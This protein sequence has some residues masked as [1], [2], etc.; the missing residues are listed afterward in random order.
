MSVLFVSQQTNDFETHLTVGC[1]TSK[2][3]PQPFFHSMSV[4]DQILF[5]L[6]CR[7]THTIPAR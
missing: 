2:R 7:E 5:S 1:E 6:F 3:L 4:T